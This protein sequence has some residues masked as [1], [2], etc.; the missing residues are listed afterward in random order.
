MSQLDIQVMNAINKWDLNVTIRNRTVAVAAAL[1][2]AYRAALPSSPVSS[3][4]AHYSTLVNEVVKQELSVANEF[5]LF[6]FLAAQQTAAKF[7]ALRYS[8][9]HGDPLK[10]LV[11]AEQYDFFCGMFAVGM[12]FSP[13]EYTFFTENRMAIHGIARDMERLFLAADVLVKR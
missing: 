7:Y 3:V 12:H 11:N 6:D 5:A 8:A 4:E 10:M 13:E 1:M 9:V 2:C